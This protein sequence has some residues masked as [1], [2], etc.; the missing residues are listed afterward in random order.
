MSEP[1]GEKPTDADAD[2]GTDEQLERAWAELQRKRAAARVDGQRP[3][4]W[5]DLL[6]RAAEAPG[7]FAAAL[8]GVGVVRFTAAADCG[9][10]WVRLELA[11]EQPGEYLPFASAEGVEVRL[12]LVLWVARVC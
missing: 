2:A 7:L 1:A 3:A 6:V 10:G 11:D 12:E 8:A 5:P 4:G 9:E